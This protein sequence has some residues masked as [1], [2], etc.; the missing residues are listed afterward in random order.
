[1]THA[2]VEREP[3]CTGYP[4][5]FLSLHPGFFPFS[6]FSLQHA[7]YILLSTEPNPNIIYK[8]HLGAVIPIPFGK[9]N[10]S[11]FSE[12]CKNI[13]VQEKQK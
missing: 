11:S 8:L 6:L 10:N 12:A 1:M 2:R 9:E 7:E 5:Q 3:G 4:Q 13:L